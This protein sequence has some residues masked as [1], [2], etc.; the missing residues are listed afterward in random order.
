[1]SGGTASARTQPPRA[2]SAG[3]PVE[4]GCSTLPT[5]DPL[6][7][8]IADASVNPNSAA[9]VASIGL[10]ALRLAATT[11]LPRRTQAKY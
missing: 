1:M 3:G 7:E 5:E 6:N 8:E 10:S 4:Y 11:Q 9:Y 2:R